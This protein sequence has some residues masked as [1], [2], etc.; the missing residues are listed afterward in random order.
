M[1]SRR[2]STRCTLQ[3]ERRTGII[4]HWIRVVTLDLPNVETSVSLVSCHYGVL[5]IRRIL[6]PPATHRRSAMDKEDPSIESLVCQACWTSIFSY[7]GWQMVLAAK[8]VPDRTGFSRGYSYKTT[9]EEI[10]ERANSGCSWCRFLARP[11]A[12]NGGLTVWAACDEDSECT[13]AGEKSLKIV[14]HGQSGSLTSHQC[15]FMYT[16]A[17]K[18]FCGAFRW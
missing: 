4:P 15:Y 12:T 14:M 8:Q 11:G 5:C 1:I 18:Y 16:S 2:T 10:H 7:D 13:P 6:N 9:W 3:V 17:G